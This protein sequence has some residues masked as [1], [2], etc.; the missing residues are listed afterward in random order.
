MAD[1]TLNAPVRRHFLSRLF[2]Q[3]PKLHTIQN[4]ELFDELE[5]TKR[6][7]NNAKLSFDNCS[8]PQ[9]IEASIY[10]INAIS[11]RYNYLLGRAKELNLA[12]SKGH[13]LKG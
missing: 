1:I 11:A 9:L 4:Q 5:H 13:A 10:E 3:K 6:M 2:G 7:L 8:H 12:K